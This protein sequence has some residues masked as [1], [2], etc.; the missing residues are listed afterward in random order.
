MRE[1]PEARFLSRTDN[2]VTVLCPYAPPGKP[3]NHVHK[4]LPRDYGRQHFAPPCGMYL[5]PEDRATG[6]TFEIRRRGR[7]SFRNRGQA[8]SPA[9]TPHDAA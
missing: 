6:Y 2:T 8:T 4:V 5:N 9:G 1:V 7:R 3:H